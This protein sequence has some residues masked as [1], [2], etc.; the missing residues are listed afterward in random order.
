MK[1]HLSIFIAGLTLAMLSVLMGTA[2]A[3]AGDAPY[4][5]DIVS[6]T[7]HP[8]SAVADNLSPSSHTDATKVQRRALPVIVILIVNAIRTAGP[9]VVRS[10]PWVRNAWNAWTTRR[11]VCRE[12]RRLGHSVGWSSICAGT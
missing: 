10:W 8:L 3:H 12:L 5:A 1:V 6:A 11:D 2:P 9:W 7:T 4:A